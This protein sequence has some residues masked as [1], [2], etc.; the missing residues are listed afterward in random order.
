MNDIAETFLD[1][2]VYIKALT[3]ALKIVQDPWSSA[4]QYFMHNMMQLF[5]SGDDARLP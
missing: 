5:P 3:L 2:R 4:S 1:L